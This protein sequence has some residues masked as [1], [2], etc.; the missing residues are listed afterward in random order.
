MN[1]GNGVMMRKKK[2][3]SH[4]SKE[5]ALGWERKAAFL[6]FPK[7]GAMKTENSGRLQPAAAAAAACLCLLPTLGTHHRGT[8]PRRPDSSP[9]YTYYSCLPILSL[10]PLHPVSLKSRSI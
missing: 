2:Y 7:T 8:I 10:F 1:E 9:Y 4:E 6:L 5:A 3:W